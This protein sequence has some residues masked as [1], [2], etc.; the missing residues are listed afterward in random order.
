MP[1]NTHI[2]TIKVV[3]NTHWDREFR[4]S[5]ERTRRNLLTMMD[6]ILDILEKDPEYHSFTLDGHTILIDDYLE[7]RPEKKPLIEKF[8][9]SG[10]LVAGP[11]YTLVEEF[12]VSHEALARNFLYGK[13]GLKN[14][15]ANPEPLPTPHL[16]GDRPDSCRRFL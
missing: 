8:M 16:H 15:V 2:K 10:R 4:Q 11:W 14:M 13:K 1:Q 12:S 9:Q 5:F 7:I 6:T 3:S